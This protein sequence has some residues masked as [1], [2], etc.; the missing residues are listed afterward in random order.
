MGVKGRSIVVSA[1]F[2]LSDNP[3]YRACEPA[4]GFAGLRARGV[5]GRSKA[6]MIQD[7]T[8]FLTGGA[9]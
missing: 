6:Y 1:C 9:G 4:T 5:A 8:I 2:S 3:R 7:K